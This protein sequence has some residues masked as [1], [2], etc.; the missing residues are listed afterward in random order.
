MRYS[1]RAVFVFVLGLGIL[2]ENCLGNTIQDIEYRASKKLSIVFSRNIGMTECL[3][4]KIYNYANAN[5][6]NIIGKGSVNFIES[7]C[8][9]NVYKNKDVIKDALEAGVNLA[10]TEE[11]AKFYFFLTLKLLRTIK[12]EI[13]DNDA[14]K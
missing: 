7:I 3:F 1:M 14:R 4:A 12:I 10:P 8:I 6:I 5:K 11:D 2:F 13:G 9:E